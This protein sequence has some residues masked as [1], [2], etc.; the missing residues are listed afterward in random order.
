MS[1][2]PHSV[3]D[4]LDSLEELADDKDEVAF[5]DVLDAFGHRSFG[6][7]F[8]IFGLLELSPI[9]GIPGVPTIL[10]ALC[11]LFAAQLAI[12]HEHVWVP[13]F[14]ERRK[15]GGDKLGKAAR[16]MDGV[17]EWLDKWFHGRLARFT[18]KFWRRLVGLSII[19]LAC[20]VPFLEVVPFASS[21]PMF[22][23]ALLG[24]ALIV[25]DGL[26][27]LIGT[28]LAAAALGFAG[29]YLLFAGSGGG[30]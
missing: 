28:A 21:A 27:V 2:E 15:M 14:V 7:F 6:P 12:G 3:G 29:Y 17:G 25:R 4:T 16:K 24:L 23:I 5:G 10:A 26:L 20:T 30:G 9:G 22:A 19:L 1:Q 13:Y 11:V 8:L 18:N